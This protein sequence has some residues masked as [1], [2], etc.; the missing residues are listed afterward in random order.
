MNDR[1]SK[2]A[3]ETLAGIAGKIRLHPLGAHLRLT[4]G[5]EN[6]D[7]VW[8]FGPYSINQPKLVGGRIFKKRAEFLEW[9]D[10]VFRYTKKVLRRDRELMEPLRSAACTSP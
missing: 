5:V 9:A 1:S 8:K 3:P 4:R 7:V 10:R 6:T 2:C